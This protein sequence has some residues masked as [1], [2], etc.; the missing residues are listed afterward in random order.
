MLV[1]MLFRTAEVV[2]SATKGLCAQN[3]SFIELHG[4]QWLTALRHLLRN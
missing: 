3:K 2:S 4:Y 1:T